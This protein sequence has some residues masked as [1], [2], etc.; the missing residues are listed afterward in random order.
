MKHCLALDLGVTTGYAV[1]SESGDLVDYGEITFDQFEENL[2]WL[3]DQWFVSWSVAEVP[4]VFRGPLGKKLEMV[5]AITRR[6]LMRQVDEVEAS[7]WKQT[8][9]KTYKVP[10]GVSQHVRDAIRLGAWYISKRLQ[11][12]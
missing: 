7:A 3:R 2:K 12:V 9:F 6:E 4:V 8:S 1:F 11:G 5:T 10:R